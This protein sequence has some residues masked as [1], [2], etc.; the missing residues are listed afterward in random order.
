MYAGEKGAGGGGNMKN[1]AGQDKWDITDR[2][3]CL[4][5]FPSIV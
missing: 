5:R 1:V 3:K 2:D 4:V